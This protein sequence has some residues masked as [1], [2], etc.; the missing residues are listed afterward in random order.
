VTA[1]ALRAQLAAGVLSPGEKQGT[2]NFLRSRQD[3]AGSW[4][5]YW[6]D[7]AF[8]STYHCLRAIADEAD[9]ADCESVQG[10]VSWLLDGQN[11]DGSWGRLQ[12][13]S[14][15]AFDTALAVRALLLSHPEGFLAEAVQNGIVWLMQ[16]QL[17][18]GSW[19]PAP[20]LRIPSADV[21]APWART[22]WGESPGEPNVLIRD[23]QA[24]F[25]TSTVLS[26]LNEFYRLAGDVVLARPAARPRP[27]HREIAAGPGA[28][29][30]PA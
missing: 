16:H 21:M 5:A 7:G 12:P 8:Y 15:R 18:D 24:L 4:Q 28:R 17:H 29:M 19:S 27:A 13:P 26:A 23:Q 14:N 6:W 2:L 9:S 30:E 25:T 10:T 20:L 11:P 3:R 1:L 22:S